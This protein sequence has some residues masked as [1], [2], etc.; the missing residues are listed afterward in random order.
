M[1]KEQKKENKITGNIAI[2][3]MGILSIGAFFLPFVFAYGN[4]TNGVGLLRGIL[5]GTTE[6]FRDS[7]I[8]SATFFQDTIISPDAICSIW[9]YLS[10]IFIILAMVSALAMV[11]FAVLQIFEKKVNPIICKWA[12]YLSAIFIILAFVFFVV[13]TASIN[14]TIEVIEIGYAFVLTICLLGSTS[15]LNYLKTK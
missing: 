3:V 11:I 10:T 6:P 14:S 2:I 15:V 5:Y 9:A 7:D 4:S 12:S 13:R 8:V 1:N